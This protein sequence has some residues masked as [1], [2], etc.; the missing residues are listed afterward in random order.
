MHHVFVITRCSLAAAAADDDDEAVH[1]VVLHQL[2][3]R[4][5]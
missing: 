3:Q 2:E 5:R 1:P 4:R